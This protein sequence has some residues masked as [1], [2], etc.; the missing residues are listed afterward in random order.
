MTKATAIKNLEQTQTSVTMFYQV[1]MSQPTSHLFEVTLHVSNWQE[2]RL[3]LKMPVWTPGSYLVREYA[4]HL[5]DF[6]AEDSSSQ[7]SLVSH[8]VS[9]NHWQIITDKVSNIT[10][11][12]RV[13]ANDLT[14]RTNHLDATHGYF[15]PAA[16]L[17][18]IPGLTQQAITVKIVPPQK[19]WQ[20][21]TTL[22]TV[23][24]ENNTYLAQ[25]F[26]TLV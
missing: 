18:F 19:D 10:V 6:V 12:Y 26:D 20:V 21:S 25:D 24:G 23:A 15:N 7:K 17:M 2:A 8:K 16:L 3:N 1:G 11:I 22:T 9:K 5:Q 14:V 13:Y 4:R